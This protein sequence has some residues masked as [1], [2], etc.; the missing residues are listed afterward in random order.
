[1]ASK[2]TEGHAQVFAFEPSPASFSDL[3][4][5]VSELNGCTESVTALPIALWSETKML[6][7]T[8]KSARA[9][10]A[11]HRLGEWR[12]ETARARRRWR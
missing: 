10:A 9:G 7:V 1:M 12:E 3:V 5:N 6:P 2:A 11:R 4:Q 8:W